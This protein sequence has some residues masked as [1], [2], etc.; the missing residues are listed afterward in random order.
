M[1]VVFP[2]LSYIIFCFQPVKYPAKDFISI[3]LNA[4]CG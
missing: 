4:P 3:I 2:E 1:S